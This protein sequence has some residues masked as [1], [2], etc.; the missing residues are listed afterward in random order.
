[1]VYSVAVYGLTHGRKIMPLRNSRLVGRSSFWRGVA[2]AFD[3][4]AQA[5]DINRSE[6]RPEVALARDWE[7]V[8]GDLATAWQ[9]TKR[10][11]DTRT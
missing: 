2:Q 9:I 10:D 1:M 3:L 11:L 6:L 8:M 7:I 5:D 4:F